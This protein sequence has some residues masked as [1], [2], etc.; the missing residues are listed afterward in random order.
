VG[1]ALQDLD[2]LTKENLMAA[3]RNLELT[4]DI[5][6]IMTNVQEAQV[7]SETEVETIRQGASHAVISMIY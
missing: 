6:E 4:H 2:T 7:H 5:N 3:A 1:D